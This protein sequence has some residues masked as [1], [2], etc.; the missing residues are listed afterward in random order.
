MC[1]KKVFSKNFPL[2]PPSINVKHQVKVLRLHRD[3]LRLILSSDDIIFVC[4]LN[5]F[6]TFRES[7]HVLNRF[8]KGSLEIE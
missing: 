3:S 8:E 7:N 6:A 2:N 4:N 5:L 1:N